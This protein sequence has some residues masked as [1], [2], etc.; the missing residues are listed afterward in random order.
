MIEAPARE[1]NPRFLIKKEAV[2]EESARELNPRFLIKKDTKT[3]S[4]LSR[5]SRLPTSYRMVLIVGKKN[6]NSD[7]L[8]FSILSVSLFLPPCLIEQRAFWPSFNRV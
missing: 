1:L 5:T 6:K 3:P 2:I 4:V 8:P 7:N